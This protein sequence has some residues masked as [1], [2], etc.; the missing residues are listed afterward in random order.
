MLIE[1]LVII[2][3]IIV[4][5]IFLLF[6]KSWNVYIIFKNDNL[7]YLLSLIVR[8][9][10][11]KVSIKK[12]NLSTDATFYLNIRSHSKKLFKKNFKN[13]EENDEENVEENIETDEDSQDDESLFIKIKELCPLLFDAREELCGV[14]LLIID[15]I[16]FK[17][18]TAKINLG[19]KD[20]NLTIK[21]CNLIWM[22]SAPLYPLKFQVLLTPEI[23]TLILKS[24]MKISFDMRLLNLIKIVYL[25]I[26][27][28][29]LRNIVKSIG[30]LNEFR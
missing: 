1:I 22:L 17:K 30:N 23:N 14:V 8:F 21:L 24:D 4:L 6:F 25:F 16:K 10:F 29:K 28:K 7:N 11:I 3:I 26:S 5:T 13:D 18:S 20:N 9:L 15:I 2:L 27:N 19:L 12:D